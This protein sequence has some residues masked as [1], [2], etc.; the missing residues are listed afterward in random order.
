M[1]NENNQNSSINTMAR[2]AVGATG[3]AMLVAFYSAATGGGALGSGAYLAILS[4]IPITMS[5]T[6]WKLLGNN[7]EERKESTAVPAF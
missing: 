3:V 2:I 5:I 1:K 4:I 7:R 6:G